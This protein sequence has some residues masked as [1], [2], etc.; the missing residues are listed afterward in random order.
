MPLGNT[1]TSLHLLKPPAG[2]RGLDRNIKAAYEAL[3]YAARPAGAE[4]QKRVAI[5]DTGDANAFLSIYDS[6]N[7]LIDNGELKQLAVAL[8]K[9]LKTAAVLTSIYDSDHFEFIVFHR[10]KQVDAVVSDPDQ[11][12]A[13]LKM[14]KAGKRTSQ[15][16]QIFFVPAL[17]RVLVASGRPTGAAS[18][19]LIQER[20][21]AFDAIMGRVGK[22]EGAF[23]EDGLSACCE[24]AGLDV[25]HAL[26]RDSDEE[27]VS[28]SSRLSFEKAAAGPA[29]APRVAPGEIRLA[30]YQSDDDCPWLRYFPA[31][32][33]F[34]AGA[35]VRA[36]WLV[37]S[38]GAGFSDLKLTFAFAGAPAGMSGKLIV[39]ALPFYNGQITS[40]TPIASFE[41]SAPAM[42]DGAWMFDVAPF[43][44]PDL[45]PEAR[46]R[47]VLIVALEIADT[48]LAAITISPSIATASSEPLELPPV[49]L[50]AQRPSWIPKIAGDAPAA[51]T[52]AIIKL[53][54]PSVLSMVALLDHDAAALTAIRQWAEQWL[55]ALKV[56]DGAELSVATHKHMSASFRVAKT[57]KTL[58]LSGAAA[59]SQWPKLFDAK[60]D[61]QTVMLRVMPAGRAF[62]IAG[63]TWQ[64][65]LRNGLRPDPDQALKY[66]RDTVG[67]YVG[68]DAAP[69][70]NDGGSAVSVALWVLNDPAIFEALGT[71]PD[72]LAQMFEAW[73]AGTA[74][75]QA[76]ITRAAWFPEL[77]FYEQYNQTLYETASTI[78]WFRSHMNGL[79]ASRAWACRRL[80]FMAST[81]WLGK[82][83]ASQVDME[84][85]ATVAEL[86]PANGATCVRS[87][88]ERSLG[89]LEAALAPILPM[90]RD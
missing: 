12:A 67:P 64:A 58:P 19:D 26:A 65:A 76:W 57:E 15:W 43:A 47:I 78:D 32:W 17:Q 44:V 84:Q 1:A 79:L 20:E 37:I 69:M 61:Y 49:K 63:F 68:A 56:A 89:E 11:H 9:R 39:R 14:M 82:E 73:M 83:L 50:Q 81:L 75:T 10:G 16:K 85:L 40:M 53:N 7:A 80:R 59:H 33:P 36:D 25:G 66:L 30:F 21:R 31:A 72:K 29:A 46:N 51:K 90:R 55:A 54:E 2:V 42:S 22:I 38:S 3:G 8:S 62:P 24:A 18:M 13:G 52:S 41:Q 45:N 77:D 60:S 48:G 70:E 27:G 88:P 71:T 34:V 28:A 86:S 6:D 23:A 5:A 35:P 87:R 74:P 4:S